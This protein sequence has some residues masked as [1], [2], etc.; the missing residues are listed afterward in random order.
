MCKEVDDTPKDNP[1]PSPPPRQETPEPAPPP[2]PPK[3]EPK[4]PEPEPEIQKEEP[5]IEEPPPE[6]PEKFPDPTWV[7]PS[8]PPLIPEP[9][10]YSN[11]VTGR[12]PTL[13]SSSDSKSNTD[14][15]DFPSQTSQSADRKLDRSPIN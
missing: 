12:D 3:E 15:S 2:P 13:L 4:E 1:A 14:I 7:K 9:S 6:Q 10:I 8:V 5:K 11:Y